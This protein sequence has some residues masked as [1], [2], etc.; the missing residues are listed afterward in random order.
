MRYKQGGESTA[1]RGIVVGA[2]GGD[3]FN[4]GKGRS[5]TEK[6]GG[7]NTA[8][9]GTLEHGLRAVARGVRAT[10]RGDQASSKGE[11]MEQV[12]PRGVT[13]KDGVHTVRIKQ[14]MDDLRKQSRA[15]PGRSE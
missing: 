2:D 1:K 14:R 15:I 3:A 10:V 6:E 9:R 13:T 8:G 7:S 11:V 4:I 5:S 12:E